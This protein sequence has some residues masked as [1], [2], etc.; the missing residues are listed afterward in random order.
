MTFLPSFLLAIFSTLDLTNKKS[1][2]ILISHPYLVLLPTFTCLS[3]AKLKIC[4]DRRITFSPK[5]SLVNILL[6]AVVVGVVST[7]KGGLQLRF[8]GAFLLLSFLLFLVTAVFTLLFLYLEKILCC[9]CC[10]SAGRLVRVFDP[11]LPHNTFILEEGRVVEL[12]D[13]DLEQLGH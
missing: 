11:D 12:T 7:V 13:N 10:G 6:N 1:L 4:G 8:L 5:M 9:S 3:Y 2:S